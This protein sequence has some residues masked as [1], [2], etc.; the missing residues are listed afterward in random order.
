MHLLNETV[1]ASS[2][3][4]EEGILWFLYITLSS[5]LNEITWGGSTAIFCAIIQY[6]LF[7]I[8]FIAEAKSGDLATSVIRK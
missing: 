6:S 4:Y 7:F 2:Q 1:I 3:G 8:I 5:P